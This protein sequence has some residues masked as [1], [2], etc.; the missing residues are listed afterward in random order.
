VKLSNHHTCLQYCQ[1]VGRYCVSAAAAATA[2]D[3]CS[4]EEEMSCHGHL[5]DGHAICECGARFLRGHYGSL[6][7]FWLD[8]EEMQ[9]RVREMV[10]NFGIL[11]FQFYDAFEGFSRPPADDASR[12]KCAIQGRPVHR[13]AVEAAVREIHRLGGRSWLAV[14]AAAT[15]PNDHDLTHGQ[16]VMP[17]EDVVKKL[18]TLYFEAAV[19]R[20]LRDAAKPKE[21]RLFD[22]DPQSEQTYEAMCGCDINEQDLDADLDP[23]SRLMDVVCMNGAWALRFVPAWADFAVRMGFSGIHWDTFG[24]FGH[25]DQATGPVSPFGT[26][27]PQPDIPGFLRAA[28][29]I[30]QKKGLLQTLNFVNG[31][32]WD[33]NLLLEDLGDKLS[34]QG[35]RAIAFPYW[36]VWSPEAEGR[37]FE[38]VGSSHGF[39]LSMYPGYSKHHCCAKN[40]RQNAA[41][42]GV[43]P[44]ELGLKRWKRA[45]D[46]GGTY[47]LIVD[48]FRYLQGP[49]VPDAVRFSQREVEQIQSL[50]QRGAPGA[51]YSLYMYAV[52]EGGAIFRQR[53]L[54]MSTETDWTLVSDQGGV[55]ALDVAIDSG[56]LFV[57]NTT[58]HVLSQAASRTT[59][60]TPWQVASAGGV[61]SIAIHGGTL[62]GVTAER[63]LVRQSLAEMTV[64]SD[65]ASS[66]ADEV[67]QEVTSIFISGGT[68]YGV[69]SSHRVVKTPL[70]K[71]EEGPWEVV[72]APGVTSV[73]IY[74]DTIY[75][76]STERTIVKQ[77][78]S[79]MEKDTAWITAAKGPVMSIAVLSMLE[80]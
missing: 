11:E 21:R 65:W 53:L 62:Y 19:R 9:N 56:F 52:S 55:K 3:E 78:L 50:V 76:S 16:W 39:V 59:R 57:V 69:D 26:G 35:G 24:D 44:F 66:W 34:W 75:A 28:L 42:Y 58:G 17:A 68:L 38:E 32:G 18:D 4:E 22:A 25:I 60:T 71:I 61:R 1:A 46:K 40:E 20:R 45:I 27:A 80:P 23:A 64:S 67:S 63:T 5:E 6:S 7:E 30:L 10:D 54:Y 31:Y 77:T 8:E 2:G 74:G 37:F 72:S 70:D 49:F 33:P 12:W 15:D 14:H 41:E 51:N 36:E 79:K 43:W 13:D 48:G 47:H 29:P 73:S